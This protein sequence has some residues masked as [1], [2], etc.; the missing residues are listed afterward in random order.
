MERRISIS[1]LQH[2]TLGNITA[3]LQRQ[4]AR[5]LMPTIAHTSYDDFWKSRNIAAHLKNV[6]TPVLTVGGW[7]DAEDAQGPVHNLS[8]DQSE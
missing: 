4:T 5:L 1:F 7:Y 2:L 3:Q 6:K 8:G